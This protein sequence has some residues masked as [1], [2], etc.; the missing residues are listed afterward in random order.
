VDVLRAAGADVSL[1][2]HVC[3]GRPLISQ[4]LLEDARGL[5]EQNVEA[6]CGAASSGRPIV[7]LEPSCLSAV[8]EDAPSLL[9]GELQR[10][11][12]VVADACTMFEEF[13][14]GLDLPLR[15]GPSRILLHG[16]CHQKSMGLL[17]STKALLGRIPGAQ[18][19]DL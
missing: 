3:C 2:P 18:L 9:R 4:G 8:K 12:R 19:T 14:E 16:H 10:K 17:D 15:S 1:I 11:A 5:A 13:A 6:L 7:F